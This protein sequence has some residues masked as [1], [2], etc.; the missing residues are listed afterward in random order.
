M[1]FPEKNIVC[2]GG[3]TGLP[4]L[5]SG[6]KYN[7]FF[8]VTAIVNVFDSGGSSGELKDRFGILPPGDVLKC[9]LALSENENYAKK[10]L[11]KRINN[12]KFPG[13]TGGNALLLGLERIFG[14]YPAAI[15][16]LS[17]LLAIRGQVVPVT[18]ESAVLCAQY[19]DGTIYKSETS[20][21]IGIREG[22]RIERIFLEPE[23][24]ASPVAL[25]AIKNA[26]L[27]CIGPGSFYTSVL[28]NF[29]PV[30]IKQ[31]VQESKAR[32]IFIANFLTEGKGMKNLYLEDIVVMVEEYIGRS[33]DY[34]IM[35]DVWPEDLLIKYSAESK[36]PIIFRINDDKRVIEADLWQ[37]KIVARHDSARLAGLIARLVM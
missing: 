19:D 16:A 4:V 29:L 10:I 27:I 34:I 6:L 5:L 22:K 14:D 25:E 7:P 9:V 36:Y 20:I 11:L 26:D 3:G 24:S 35:N 23:I 12:F 17:Q 37:D 21:D 1:K 32:V 33:L 28:S 30:G 18:Q 31:A 15:E 2:F 8:K 13:H